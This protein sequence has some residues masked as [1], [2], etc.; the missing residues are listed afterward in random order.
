MSC[1]KRLRKEIL[2]LKKTGPDDDIVLDPS[3]DDV[4]LWKAHIRGPQGTPFEGGV[5]E[6]KVLVGQEYPLVPPTMKFVTKIFHPNIHFDTG[7][8]CLDIL[9]KEW[10]PAWNLQAS[11]F[12]SV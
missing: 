1:L 2:A 4:R 7:E 11:S 3:D 8:I 10:S 12:F 6:L 5:F 9:K